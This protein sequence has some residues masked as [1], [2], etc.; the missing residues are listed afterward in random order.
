[1]LKQDAP[2]YPNQVDLQRLKKKARQNRSWVEIDG[3]YT[4]F[5]IAS[6]NDDPRPTLPWLQLAVDHFTGQVLFHDLA[7]PDQCLTAADFTRTAQQFLVTLIQET[8]QRPSGILISNQDLYYALGSL[9]RKLGITCSKSAELPKL[10]ETREA[11]F[12]AMNR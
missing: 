8:G 10:S 1:M 5:S 9:C 12:A 2:L 4:P 7:S 6:T 11:M 3:N